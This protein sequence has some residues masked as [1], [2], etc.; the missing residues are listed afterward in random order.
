MT[1]DPVKEHHF[2]FS[3]RRSGERGGCCFG[4]I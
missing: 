1:Q 3:L 2:G 4:N